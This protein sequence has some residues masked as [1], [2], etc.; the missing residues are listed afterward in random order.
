MDISLGNDIWQLINCVVQ[1]V[2]AILA[3]IAIIL[4]LRQVSSTTK[5]K[6]KMYTKFQIGMKDGKEAVEIVLHIVN[7]GMAPI[8]IEGW[9]VQLWNYGKKKKTI[10]I[11]EE[12]FELKPGKP[13]SLSS[14]YPYNKVNDAASL[15]DKVCIYIKYRLGEIYYGKKEL[16]DDLNFEYK[17]VRDD[18]NRARN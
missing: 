16:Y 5:V 17:K 18:A 2:V 14:Y 1:A 8:F 6:F 15:H 7:L 3:W 10:T 12:I 11:S 13:Y 9:G 4:T